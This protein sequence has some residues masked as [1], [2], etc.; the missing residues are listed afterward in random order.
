MTNPKKWPQSAEEI[1]SLV[2][3]VL[4]LNEVDAKTFWASL[5][6]HNACDWQK[7][8]RGGRKLALIYR[9]PEPEEIRLWANSALR[10]STI[11]HLD[12][13]FIRDFADGLPALMVK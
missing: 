1:N 12:E 9:N 6:A 7:E 11:D 8:A 2:R 5:Q 3:Q 10:N 13:D 4:A